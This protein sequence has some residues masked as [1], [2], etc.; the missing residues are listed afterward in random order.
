MHTTEPK[1]AKGIGGLQAATPHPP[2]PSF[3]TSLTRSLEGGEVAGH[4]AH[5]AHVAV[6]LHRLGRIDVL[7]CHE[8]AW[9]VC[10]SS[11]GGGA[12]ERVAPQPPR[13]H[14]HHTTY[15]LPGNTP[16]PPPH[17]HTHMRRWGWPPGQ[18][19]PGA[20][21]SPGRRGRSRCP[22]QTKTSCMRAAVQ[23][24][25]GSGSGSGAGSSRAGA[26]GM[27]LKLCSSSDAAASPRCAQHRTHPCPHAA[28]LPA[29]RCTPPHSPLLAQHRPAAPQ[30]LLL[31]SGA[32]Y[33]P[34]LR[35]GKGHPA[36]A[37]NGGSGEEPPAMRREVNR[38]WLAAAAPL[39]TQ[40]R[41]HRLH[42][43]SPDAAAGVHL[44]L[45]PVHLHNVAHAPRHKPL[46]Q[47]QRDVPARCGAVGRERCEQ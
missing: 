15:T 8:P 34:V 30:R 45:P 46:P 40:V 43:T 14:H 38:C 3:P 12:D 5:A 18:R 32:A 37:A 4:A 10:S 16:S 17:P 29:T 23:C 7:D 44:L 20:A 6:H 11:S 41:P 1:G 36:A 39:S 28:C 31:A 19:A 42:R 47:A 21:Q 13:P 22:P 25:P 33:R 2:T 26:C 35:R 9:G 27:M 24:G